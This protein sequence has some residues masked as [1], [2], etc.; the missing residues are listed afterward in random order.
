M[1][2]EQQEEQQEQQICLGQ[3]KWF[4]LKTGFGFISVTDG[5]A[6]SSDIFVH[7]SSIRVASEQYRYLVQGEYVQFNLQ[8]LAEGTSKHEYQATNVTGIRGGKMMCE[9]RNE[10][11][12]KK[13][14]K[15]LVTDDKNDGY[16]LVSKRRTYGKKREN[17]D[18]EQQTQSE[19]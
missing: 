3:V 1:T 6:G 9:L 10:T 19:M 13:G 14:Y 4:N 12:E 7:H 5:P 18:K 16:K 11:R 8:K 15:H 2:T 17:K